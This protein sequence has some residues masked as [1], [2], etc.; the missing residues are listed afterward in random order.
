MFKLKWT[1]SSLQKIG[2][3]ASFLMVI[4]LVS[5]SLIYL[6]GQLASAMGPCTYSLAD[7]L[8]GPVWAAC[9]VTV[10]LA[11]R[12]RIGEAAPRRMN[13][14]LLA[15][16]A[17]ACAFVMIACIRASNRH[18]HLIHPELHLESS[19][20]ILT[21]WAALVAS[22]IGAAFH[23]LGWALVLIGSAGWASKQLPL[24]LSS[25]YLWAGIMCMLVFLLPDME[26]S[27]ITLILIVNIWQGFLLLKTE[28][29]GTQS[30]E[31][32]IR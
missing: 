12:D 29:R 5:S 32:N 15:S 6:T 17:A 26:S 22:A 13:L 24:I 20:V 28:P 2:G 18:Y 21:I 23:I 27:A 31:L 19:E 9:L 1:A 30:S 7:F 25:L 10:V 8:Y 14:A 16:F 3:I 11:L 4:A